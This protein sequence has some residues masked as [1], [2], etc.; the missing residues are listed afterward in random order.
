MFIKEKIMSYEIKKLLPKHFKV[1]DLFLLG[2]K[3]KEIA[4]EL[5]MS[6]QAVSSI[7]NSRVFK[8]ELPKR[9]S[10]VQEMKVEGELS[11]GDLLRSAVVKSASG[12]I[13]AHGTAFGQNYRGI[14]SK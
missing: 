6:E 13:I 9:K 8:E 5:C 11:A 3:Q 14:S 4:K 7:V 1:M 10:A 12:V 2:R